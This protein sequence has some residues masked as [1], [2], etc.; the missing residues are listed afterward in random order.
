[1]L[2]RSQK[3]HI[4]EGGAK[5]TAMIQQ[6]QRELDASREQLDQ[7]ERRLQAVLRLNRSLAEASAGLIDGRSLM[8][9]AL[10]AI[11]ELAGALGCSFVPID[12]WQQPFP[13]L[14]YGQLP[15]PVL[16]AWAAH[17]AN[18]MLRDRC[19]NC[20]VLHSTPGACPLHPTQ[21]G[22]SLAIYCI[23][24]NPVIQN[25]AVEK[26]FAA[27]PSL[28]SARQMAQPAGVL[29]LYLPTG[30]SLDAETYHFLEGLLGQIAL[31]YQASRLREQEQVTLRQLQM[32]HAPEGDFTASLGVLLEGLVQALEA[33]F[34]LIRVRHLPEER[35]AGL[36]AMCGDFS[37][38]AQGELERIIDAAMS[39]VLGPLR[40]ARGEPATS[41][42]ECLPVWFALPLLRPEG[43][44]PDEN[45][46]GSLGILLVGVDHPYEFHPRQRVIIQAVA[47][48]SALLV[49]NERLIRSLEYKT[50]IQERAR[51][52]REIH[53]GLAQTLAFLKLQAAQMQ[54]YL[55]Q[56]DLTRLGRILKD[57][58]QTLAEAYLDTRQAIDDLRLTPQ[59]GLERW[60]ERMLNE[61]ENVTGLRVERDIRPLARQ[62]APE[63]QAQL[64]RIVQEA[65]SNVRKHARARQVRVSLVE[66]KGETVLEV[67]DDGQGFSDEDVPDVTRHGLRGMRERAELL[68]ADFQM[69]SQPLQG[70]T[71]RLVLPA[72]L[73][74]EPL[75]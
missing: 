68:G 13:A 72:T 60:L 43:T 52:A 66:R 32:L 15:E 57:N 9:S 75:R 12:E 47:A 62:L 28:G 27:E 6:K 29:H 54:S 18:G 42:D 70:T 3:R 26:G 38:F 45:T 69:I 14:T 51:L 55:A 37:S 58:Y 61:F 20:S 7:T 46:P 36:N 22:S 19:G 48:Q 24:Q 5:T 10:S 4:S 17:L 74:E 49:E 2:N 67:S 39:A 53:D 59:D 31:A 25:G 63:V 11:T 71:M 33:D 1:M 56:G 41:P 8:D 50:V 35:L 65:L 23:L 73:A 30:R 64:V 21:A 40:S 34:A 16:N 44:L